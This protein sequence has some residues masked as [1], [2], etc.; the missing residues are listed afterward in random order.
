MLTVHNGSTGPAVAV[1]GDLVEA[2]G[3]LAELTGRYAQARVRDWP[4]TVGPALAHSGPPPQAPSPRERIHALLR[5]G[6]TALP[7]ADV[8]DLAV[9]EAAARAGV[10]LLP[11]GAP[12]PRLAPGERADLAVFAPDG[13]CL[14]TVL[15]GRV[16]HRRA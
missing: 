3:P 7:V 14:A 6:V 11:P 5:L 10:R 9:R 8:P 13:R 16:V 1:R 12:A 15:A 2:V 4:G